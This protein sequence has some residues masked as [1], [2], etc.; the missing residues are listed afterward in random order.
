MKLAMSLKNEKPAIYPTLKLSNQPLHPGFIPTQQTHPRQRPP[1]KHIRI[2]TH[3]NI[4][5]RHFTTSASQ[6]TS[7]EEEVLPFTCEV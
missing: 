1:K 5:L 7:C 3:R 2:H 6:L 4:T